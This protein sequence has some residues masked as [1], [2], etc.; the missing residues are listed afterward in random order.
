MATSITTAELEPNISLQC[1]LTGQMFCDPVIAEDGHTYEREA[2]INW[3]QKHNGTSPITQQLLNI[4]KLQS[5]LTIKQL[6]EQF[7]A[8]LRNKKYQ[9]TLDVDVKKSQRLFQAFGKTVH[10]AEWI[11]HNKNN[12]PKVIVMTITGVRAEK[13]ASFYVEL[14]KHPHIVRTYGLV[15]NPENKTSVM[16]LQEYAAKGDLL[17][18]LDNFRRVPDESVLIEIFI[19]ISDAMNFLAYNRIVHGDLACRN[20]LVFRFDEREPENTLVKVTDFGLSRGSSIYITKSSATTTILN[21]IPYRYAAPEILQ[22]LTSNEYYSEKS[23]MYS[24]GVLMWEAY[25]KGIMPWSEIDNDDDVLKKVIGG[26]RLQMPLACSEQIWNI[27]QATM[28]QEPN[29]RP[30]F[31]KLNRMLSECQIRRTTTNTIS[32]TLSSSLSNNSND[33]NQLLEHIYEVNEYNDDIPKLFII[34]HNYCYEWNSEDIWLNKFSLYFICQ[35]Q[36]DNFHLLSE[37]YTIDNPKLFLKKY[38]SYLT[39]MIKIVKNIA[40]FRINSKDLHF[41]DEEKFWNHFS[42]GLDKVNELLE[43]ILYNKQLEALN[44][45]H[46]HLYEWSIRKP[47]LNRIISSN[48]KVQW[49]C[50]AHHPLDL[51][52]HIKEFENLHIKIDKHNGRIILDGQYSSISIEEFCIILQKH[53]YF[54][55][56]SFYYTFVD[57]SNID[58][59]INSMQMSVFRNLQVKFDTNYWMGGTSSRIQIGKC[60][61]SFDIITKMIECQKYLKKFEIIYCELEKNSM[62][63]LKNAISVN[64][65]LSTFSIKLIAVVKPP[66]EDQEWFGPRDLSYKIISHTDIK[67]IAIGLNL[68]QNLSHLILTNDGINDTGAY[69]IGELLKTNKTLISLDLS[70]NEIKTKGMKSITDAL[71]KNPILK[72]IFI[73][74]NQLDEESGETIAD[75]LRNNKSI[76]NINISQNLLLDKAAKEIANALQSNQTLLE[77]DISHNKIE[78][79]GGY[80]FAQALRTNRTLKYL[81]IS[82]N[83]IFKEGSRYFW[84][85]LEGNSTLITLNVS[86]CRMTDKDTY[87][88]WSNI[89]RNEGLKTL[90]ISCG[91]IS[92]KNIEGIK[93][94]LSDDTSLVRI[95]MEAYC[96]DITA[97]QATTI[98]NTLEINK[99]LAYFQLP[100]ASSKSNPAIHI[101]FD[102]LTNN[103]S[104]THLELRGSYFSTTP[105]QFGE[106]IAKMLHKNKYLKYLNI[107]QN[108]ISEDGL[109][110]ISEALIQNNNLTDLDIGGIGGSKREDKTIF[111]V[112]EILKANSTLLSLNITGITLTND[113]VRELEQALT[114]NKSLI[115]LKGKNTSYTFYGGS[116]TGLKQITYNKNI[117][118]D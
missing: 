55:E 13:E 70:G 68:N 67:E 58:D 30:T 39:I 91:E 85:C 116:E 75:L 63:L 87:R 78:S 20:I 12:L 25:S 110:C 92:Q 118:F 93:Y 111:Y 117:Y 103:Q 61:G 31:K 5:N 81:N 94:F 32:S 46:Q 90:S 28:A 101:I 26:E 41:Q 71:I 29:R 74:N 106:V 11:K 65:T 80:A 27:I 86:D 108:R 37:S 19:Q 89:Y 54:Y 60:R 97:E 95:D 98:A 49:V 109:K 3:L 14:S 105:K 79:I 59:L 82:K 96:S 44:E 77:L 47:N 21:I 88:P 76:T 35:C 113:G 6:I 102:G 23:D 112:A 99:K 56:L 18:F 57:K 72:K 53:I 100:S 36:S 114:T 24:M 40:K 22:N 83:E 33:V 69:E 51:Q 8:I 50:N 15:D 4:N 107:S 1:P 43:K 9:F 48:G 73:S 52:Q 84:E 17:E 66:R 45:I 7:E 2:I 38:G 115:H 104:I 34:L 16:L 64:R 42:F 62:E 10:M